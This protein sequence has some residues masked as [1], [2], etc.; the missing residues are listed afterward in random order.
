MLSVTF[1]LTCV[2]SNLDVENNLA[3]SVQVSFESKLLP[4]TEK[5]ASL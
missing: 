5:E 2:S 1:K 4:Q 3:K